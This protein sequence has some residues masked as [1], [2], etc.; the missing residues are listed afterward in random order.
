MTECSVGIRIGSRVCVRDED[1]VVEFH[2]VD[3]AEADARAK[4]LSAA[5]PLG[6]ALLDRRVG[7]LV[8]FRAPGGVL[9]V[10]VVE[11]G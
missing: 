10:T 5:S 3:P 7:D 2:I 8:H 6:R 1:G 11:V 9:A 4:R